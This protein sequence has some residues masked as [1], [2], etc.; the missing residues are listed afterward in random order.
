M[1]SVLGSGCRAVVCYTNR[2]HNYAIG[3]YVKILRVVSGVDNET[4]D[5]WSGYVCIDTSGDSQLLEAHELH[6]I[7]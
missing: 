6:K 5:I 4:G 3:T 1:D 2:H 7:D